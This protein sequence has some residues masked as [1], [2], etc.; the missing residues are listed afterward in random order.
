MLNHQ[1]PSWQAHLSSISRW[2]SGKYS[3]WSLAGDRSNWEQILRWR[4]TSKLLWEIDRLCRTEKNYD[5]DLKKPTSHHMFVKKLKWKGKKRKN[6][7][8]FPFIRKRGQGL[9]ILI[10]N[11]REK[12]AGYL[13]TFERPQNTRGLWAPTCGHRA[14][15][16]IQKWTIRLK[17]INFLKVNHHVRHQLHNYTRTP[18][19]SIIRRNITLQN[20]NTSQVCY[21][22]LIW[23]CLRQA[24][25]TLYTTGTFNIVSDRHISHCIRQTH[26]S[27][28]QEGEFYYILPHHHTLN[29]TS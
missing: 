13:S 26:L 5:T 22:W 7:F 24:H 16:K 12:Y 4:R 19:M 6:L 20:R 25:L 18:R 17:N 10:N 1:K 15:L 27:L 29:H 21:P 9:I 2:N 14:H 23:P 28:S 3:I 8:Y 11:C